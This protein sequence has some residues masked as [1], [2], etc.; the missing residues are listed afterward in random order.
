MNLR[1][2]TPMLRTPDTAATIAFYTQV[3]EF[4]L[5][6]GDAA[7]GWA[8][9]ERDGVELMLSG[10]NAHEGDLA[11]AFT[12]SLYLRTDDVDGWWRRLRERARVCY[13]IEDFG[14]GMRE[15]AIYDNNGYLLQFG[16]PIAAFDEA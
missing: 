13:P 9:L 10:L 11:P 4:R 12:G 15:F 1:A 5:S 7:G 3:L 6:A 14:Y 16:Q 8:A 2:L